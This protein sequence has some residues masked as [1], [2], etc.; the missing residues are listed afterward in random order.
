MRQWGWFGA[1][2]WLVASCRAD[3]GVALVDHT[4]APLLS[5]EIALD[6]PTTGIAD[7]TQVARDVSF[8]GTHWYAIWSDL[9]TGS[10]ELRGSRLDASGAALDGPGTVLA[11]ATSSTA[12]SAAVA[13]DGNNHVVVFRDGAN[14]SLR[15]VGTDGVAGA[16]VVLGT[17]ATP[18]ITSDGDGA[19]LI[20]QDMI[21]AVLEA[22]EAQ[23]HLEGWLMGKIEKGVPLPGLYPPNAE[24]KARY[25]NETGRKA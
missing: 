9:R 6:A 20:P 11:T 22:A 21:D 14:V 8:D 24:T 16:T 5:S 12:F 4:D 10:S 3:R 18:A 23:E 2:L 7:G 17:G 19:V 15:P 13:F 25:E 1:T